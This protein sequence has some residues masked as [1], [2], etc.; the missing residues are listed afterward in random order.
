VSN[1]GLI[2]ARISGRRVG[3]AIIASNTG[4][5]AMSE[6]R[7]DLAVLW[8]IRVS[9]EV[10]HQGIG[11]VLFRA[12]ERWAAERRYREIKVETQN[13]NVAACMFY[14]RHGFV[15]RT[16]R[17]FAYSQFPNEIQLLWYKHVLAS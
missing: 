10:R 13:I 17:P 12:V 14:A 11:S 7:S 4:S 9:P 1:W 2:A 8:D 3:G 16:I 5:A 15:L 6:G